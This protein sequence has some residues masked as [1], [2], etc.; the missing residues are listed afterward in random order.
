MK[1]RWSVKQGGINVE[2]YTKSTCSHIYICTCTYMCGCVHVH[3]HAMC[4]LSLFPC[5]WLCVCVHAWV[6]AYMHACGIRY[7]VIVFSYNCNLFKYFFF[8]LYVCILL[9]I[10]ICL[11]WIL[12]IEM[13]QFPFKDN[14][15]LC[16]EGLEWWW[17]RSHWFGW[18][19]L[20]SFRMNR[21]HPHYTV[22]LPL[23]LEDI[24][25]LLFISSVLVSLCLWDFPGF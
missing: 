6:N 2:T 8:F 12:F 9:W 16:L 15:V 20:A 25:K 19:L 21:V 3:R 14:K 22:H 18:L 13:L 1:L 23:S 24:F 5:L 10:I 11:I 4:S 17:H 7:V